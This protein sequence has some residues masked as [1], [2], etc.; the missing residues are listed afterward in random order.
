MSTPRIAT[1]VPASHIPRRSL[2]REKQFAIARKSDPETNVVPG[3]TKDRNW[4]SRSRCSMCPA[5]HINSR[6]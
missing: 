4:R 6:S 2:P 5:I 1:T 3:V